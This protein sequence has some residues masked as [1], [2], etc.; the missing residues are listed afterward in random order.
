MTWLWVRITGSLF[1]VAALAIFLNW[2]ASYLFRA[3]YPAELAI[4]IEGF[5]A[6]LVNRATL[7]RSW[8]AGLGDLSA[9]AQLRVHMSD[10]ENL[11]VPT[12]LASAAAQ[13]S[14]AASEPDFA[15]LLANADPADGERR[16]TVCK[17]CHTF[18]EGGANGVGPNLWGVVGH[19]IGAKASFEYSDAMGSEAGE[20]TFEKL[21]AY[22]T[23]PARAI[24]GNKMAFPGV[25]RARDRAEVIAFLRAQGAAD[26]PLPEPAPTPA[27][28]AGEESEQS[29]T[30]E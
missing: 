25:R 23:N 8:P 15:T 5:D 17:A 12:S 4:E 11:T 10:V 19:D 30:V 21:D 29:A 14:P 7:Q 27:E 1:I 28:N 24:P 22:L 16:T 2:A 13:T 18:E 9:R 20:W 3:D 26:I 6:P